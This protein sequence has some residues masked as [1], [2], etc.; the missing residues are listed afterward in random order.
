MLATLHQREGHPVTTDV[1][2]G[3]DRGVQLWGQTDLAG[4]L[5]KS[6]VPDTYEKL[7]I[8]LPSKRG[9]SPGTGRGYMPLI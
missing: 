8:I 2:D 1:N 3:G 6:S 5:T 9:P 7:R 4:W